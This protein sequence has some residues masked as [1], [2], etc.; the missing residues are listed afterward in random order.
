[1][2]GHDTGTRIQ[3]NQVADLLGDGLGVDVVL[4]AADRARDDRIELRGR[5]II[6]KAGHVG[7]QAHLE[8]GRALLFAELISAG[9]DLDH[10][11]TLNDAGPVRAVFHTYDSHH[12]NL[13]PFKGQ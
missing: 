3:G 11:A 10:V 4:L 7:R 5:A 1:M 2:V 9:A 8:G 13:R 12:D 6:T